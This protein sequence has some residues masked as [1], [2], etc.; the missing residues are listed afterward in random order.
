VEGGPARVVVL[1]FGNPLRGDDS[2]GWVVAETAAQRWPGRVLVR[3]GQQ[4]VPEWAA[5]LGGA[6]V[7]YFV[8]A[9]VQVDE[10]VIEVL[11]LD[12]VS[13]PMDSHDLSPARLVLLARAAF[14]HAPRAMVLHVPAVNFE[15][16]DTLSPTA[17]SGVRHAERLLDAALESILLDVSQ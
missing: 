14:G 4:L 12:E 9:S 8:D 7:V 17:A 15:F 5:D 2:V 1:G 11:S 3:T 16:G 13:A 6:D 10:A